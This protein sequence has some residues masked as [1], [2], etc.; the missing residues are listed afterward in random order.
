MSESGK[1][2]LDRLLKTIQRREKI[3]V[4]I[5]MQNVTLTGADAIRYRMFSVLKES[6]KN[7]KTFLE[8]LLSVGLLQLSSTFKKISPTKAVPFEF[9]D[10]LKRELDKYQG[11]LRN[12]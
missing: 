1:D 4:N 8:L 7:E 9:L 5:A 12:D 10:D 6:G 3:V 11:E 2:T